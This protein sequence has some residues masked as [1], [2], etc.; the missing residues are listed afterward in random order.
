LLVASTMLRLG[1]PH[2]NVLSKV[3]ERGRVREDKVREVG[4]K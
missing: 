4:R 2:V 1:L 3:R